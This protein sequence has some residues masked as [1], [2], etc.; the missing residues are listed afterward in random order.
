MQH[1]QETSEMHTTFLLEN[2]KERDHSEDLGTDR[3]VREW[4]LEK[5]GGRVQIGIIWITIR[6]SGRIL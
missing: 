4:N 1:T 2:M 6:T 3:K 5:E